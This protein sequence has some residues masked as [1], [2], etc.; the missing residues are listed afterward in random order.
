MF[1]GQWKYCGQFYLPEASSVRALNHT[2]IDRLI[3]IRQQWNRHINYGGSWGSRY[4]PINVTPTDVANLHGICEFLCSDNVPRKLVFYTN[5]LY[6][7]TND[8][9]VIKRMTDT[10]LITLV[11]LS[12]A[13]VV[14]TSGTIM[15]KNPQ[16]QYRTYF[17][18]M[19]LDQS[20]CESLRNFLENQQCVRL[21]P[22]LKWWLEARYRRV[23]NYYF[24]D[25]DNPSILTMLG[26]IEPR[27]IRKTVPIVAAK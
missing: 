19:S 23:L 17:R 7:Y 26:M 21:S 3:R 5:H 22:T 4:S 13:E 11:E 12:E 8:I 18:E 20:K 1:F 16:H 2:E 27:L 14:G 24:L 10:G 6:V 25:H 9:D 15:L